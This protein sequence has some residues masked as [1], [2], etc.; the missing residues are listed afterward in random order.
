MSILTTLINYV[1]STATYILSDAERHKTRTDRLRHLIYKTIISLSI[2]TVFLYAILNLLRPSNPLSG[3]GLVTKVMYLLILS[4]IIN[5]IWYIILPMSTIFNIINKYRYSPDKQINLFQYQL[6][7]QLQHVE[8]DFAQGYAFF[9]IYIYV[10]CFY[11]LMT[12]LSS[13]ILIIMFVLQYWIDKYNLFRRHSYP[14]DLGADLNRMIF[15]IFEISLLLSAAGHFLWDF[16]IHFDM[17]AGFKVINII[18]LTIAVIYIGISFFAPGSLAKRIFKNE[19]SFEHHQYRYY[20]DNNK[21]RKTFYRENP[22]TSCL[23][24]AKISQIRSKD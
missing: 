13:P 19:T 7:E 6:D 4:P 24:E 5:L 22:A 1:L 10:A 16:S 12:P 8:F 23:K 3:L 15:K 17:T 2:N 9:I 14:T 20:L 18:N 21:F 11:S